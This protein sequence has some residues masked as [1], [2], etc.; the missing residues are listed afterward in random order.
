[1]RNKPDH[2][3]TPPNP[4]NEAPMTAIFARTTLAVLLGL[5]LSACALERPDWRVVDLEENVLYPSQREAR[6]GSHEIEVAAGAALEYM[7]TMQAGDSVSYRWRANTSDPTQLLAEFHGHT[8]REAG[9][10]GSVMIY[11]SDR[12]GSGQGYLVA[13]FSGL[14]G[15]YLN[16]ESATDVTVTLELNGFYSDAGVTEE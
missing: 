12:T 5:L 4:E 14:H 11:T 2:A 6:Q 8:I 1:M 15:W 16:N 3:T 13:P 9:E 10:Q 7:L